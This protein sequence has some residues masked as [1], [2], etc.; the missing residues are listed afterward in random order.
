MNRIIIS[1]LFALSANLAF[2]PVSNAAPMA[3]PE[4]LWELEYRDSHFKVN[5]CEGDKLCAELVWLSEGASTPE[6]T[7]YLNT[8]MVD[9]AVRVGNRT[10][11][12][13]LSLFGQQAKG[14]VTQVS[15][16]LIHLQGCVFGVVCKTFKLYRLQ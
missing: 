9:H 3:S 14:K 2:V 16:D 11:R 4:G 7:V 15:N 12:G 1:A 8:L 10:W 5:L 13:Q 6:K